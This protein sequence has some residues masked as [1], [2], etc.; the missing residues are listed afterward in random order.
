MSELKISDRREGRE[1]AALPARE[2]TPMDLLRIATSQ[3]ADLEKLEKLMELQQRWDKE[4]ARKAYAQAMA[5]AHRDPPQIFKNK[6]VNRGNAG[7]YNHATHDEVTA[8]VGNWLAR[9]GFSHA[10]HRRQ[11]EG[12]IYVKC[13]VT[14]SAGHSEGFEL[15]GLPDTTGSKSPL[16][17]IASTTTFL[18]RYTLL[19][20]T[21]LSTEEHKAADDDAAGGSPRE[22]EPEGYGQWK[23]DMEAKGDE[24]LEQLTAA[25]AKSK[26]HY[27]RYVVKFD[28]SW[29]NDVKAE[30]P[31]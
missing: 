8:K 5:E 17:A 1:V 28:E 18:E 21:G 11:E 14:H 26:S 20:G 12:Q 19:G 15:H 7:T 30:A 23:A 24:G 27:R 13:V 9:Y 3:G 16:Q 4:Q 25:W 6:H 22:P 31:K 29:W 10:W 2:V